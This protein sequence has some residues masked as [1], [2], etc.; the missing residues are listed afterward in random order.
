MYTTSLQHGFVLLDN[1]TL[2]LQP[3]VTEALISRES[4]APHIVR[5]VSV[6]Y[7]NTGNFYAVISTYHGSKQG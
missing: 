3:I 1:S 4:G 2:E 5:K 7:T 6:P